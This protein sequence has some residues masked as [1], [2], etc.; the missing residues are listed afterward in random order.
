MSA[1]VVLRKSAASQA[2][3]LCWSYCVGV[4]CVSGCVLAGVWWGREDAGEEA[5]SSKS[6]LRTHRGVPE[7]EVL[8]GFSEGLT[9]SIKVTEKEQRSYLKFSK[10]KDKERDGVEEEFLLHH[11]QQ[12]GFQM[13]EWDSSPLQLKV[14]NVK[15]NQ[16]WSCHLLWNINQSQDLLCVL[17]LVFLWKKSCCLPEPGQWVFSNS[18]PLIAQN[19]F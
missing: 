16:N 6:K 2:Y 11:W 14:Q 5:D 7:M 8:V 9:L 12:K 3:T 10:S 13:P 18:L 1:F 19:E 17:P 15:E 4:N